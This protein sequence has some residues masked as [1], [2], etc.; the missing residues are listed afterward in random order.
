MR[1]AEALQS[2]GATVFSGES[3]VSLA[4]SVFLMRQLGATEEQIEL[5][6]KRIR[7]TGIF[8]EQKV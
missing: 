2:L 4:M 1:E 5:E 8:F 6:Q 7:Q 3:E